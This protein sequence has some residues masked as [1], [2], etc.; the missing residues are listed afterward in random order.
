MRSENPPHRH[1]PDGD[2]GRG[3]RATDL[4]QRQIGLPG[5]Q[6]QHQTAMLGQARAV[7]AAH[8]TRFCMSLRTPALRPADRGADADVKPF[9]RRS[10]GSS[11]LNKADHALSQVLRVWCRHIAPNDMLRP[12]TRRSATAWESPFYD[13]TRSGTALEA[14]HARRVGEELREGMRLE[15]EL[16][17]VHSAAGQVAVEAEVLEPRALPAMAR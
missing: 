10:S 6:L 2:P 11:R 13:S 1:Q 15:F 16:R 5:D 17:Y 9:G 7:I 12:Q 4:L 3:K 14:Q 8:R